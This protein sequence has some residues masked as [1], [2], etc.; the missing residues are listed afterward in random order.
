[1]FLEIG[2]GSRECTMII[3]NSE[4]NLLIFDLEGSIIRNPILVIK[5]ASRTNQELFY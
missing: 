3:F 2:H 4:A 5:G 1:M